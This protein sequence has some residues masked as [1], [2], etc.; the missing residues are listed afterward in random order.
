MEPLAAS[1]VP[2]GALFLGCENEMDAAWEILSMLPGSESVLLGAA[3]A[4]SSSVQTPDGPRS[5]SSWARG[6]L[7]VWPLGAGLSHGLN[8]ASEFGM[9]WGSCLPL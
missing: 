8:L 7:H 5:S 2:Y 4:A 6:R 9:S 3:W 1:W